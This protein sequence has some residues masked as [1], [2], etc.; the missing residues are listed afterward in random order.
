MKKS[1]VTLAVGY[2]GGLLLFAL[3][4][5]CAPQNSAETATGPSDPPIEIVAGD[6]PSEEQR[7]AMLA[8]K[9]ALFER[10]STRLKQAMSDKGPAAAIAVCQ[11]AAPQLATEVGEEHKLRIGRSGVRLR[12]PLNQPPNW[13]QPLTDAGTDEAK[14]VRLTNGQTAALLPIKLQAQCLMC[15][16][17]EEQIAPVVSE[18]LARLY[19]DDRATGFKEGDLRGWFWIELPAS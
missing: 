9:D 13:A 11:Q 2:A 3:A 16:G 5:G 4:S 19:P 6:P 12:N 7:Q 17:P 15:H 1:L 10:L 8:A 18:Q 14:F